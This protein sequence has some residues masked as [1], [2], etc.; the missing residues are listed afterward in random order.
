ML[1][2]ILILL[3]NMDQKK[4]KA[5]NVGAFLLNFKGEM[6]TMDIDLLMNQSLKDVNQSLNITNASP[7][8]LSTKME[9]KMAIYDSHF[10]NLH[11]DHGCSVSVCKLNYYVMGM[12]FLLTLLIQKAGA[13]FL[14]LSPRDITLSFI[15]IVS[16]F[17]I[18]VII[19]GAKQSK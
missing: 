7:N 14:W 11:K 12:L 18:A 9:T 10:K 17:A 13:N 19:H 3:H 6:I 5:P 1:A 2:L 16:L 15:A 8:Y 4:K